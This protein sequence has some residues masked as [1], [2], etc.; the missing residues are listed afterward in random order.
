MRHG[1]DS[2]PSNKMLEARG[3]P[4]QVEV[5]QHRRVLEV[6]ALL[7]NAREAEHWELTRGEPPFEC[8]ELACVDAAVGDVRLHAV[9]LAQRPGELA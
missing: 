8:L 7:P 9:P 6:M 4:R 1:R 2:V 3:Q 5:A